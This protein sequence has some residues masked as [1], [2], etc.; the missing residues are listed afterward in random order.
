VPEEVA[1]LF[2]L[3]L[4]AGTLLSLV[5]MVM[6]FLERRRAGAP[7]ADDPATRALLDDMRARLESV[8]ERLDFTE[9]LLAQQRE[10]PAL[11]G[12]R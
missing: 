6:R 9:R 3:T 5:W 10:R 4:G 2:A 11:G 1:I 8:E 7:P 12:D